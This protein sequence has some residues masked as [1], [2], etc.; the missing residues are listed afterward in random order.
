M[1]PENKNATIT[2]VHKGLC[3]ELEKQ[4]DYKNTY[5][6][7]KFLEEIGVIKLKKQEKKQQGKPVYIELIDPNL[8]DMFLKFL[9]LIKPDII[10]E[11]KKNPK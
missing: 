6:H 1:N 10:K 11:L 3:H 5:K 9:E 8:K 7:I 4:Y 2:E